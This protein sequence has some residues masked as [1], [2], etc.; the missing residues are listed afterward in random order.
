[1]HLGTK[2][3]LLMLL[4]TIGSSAAVSWIVTLNV[5]SY[6][7]SRANDQIS[8]AITRYV[9]RV[10]DRQRQVSK[11]VRALLESPA[12]RSQLQA[13]DESSDEGAREQLRQ[14]IFGREVQTELTSPEGTPAFHVLVNLA[15]DVV[16]AVAPTD[17]SLERALQTAQL[18]WPVDVVANA[19]DRAGSQY[20]STP[21][22]L[23][24]AMAV[25]LRTS[26]KTG[27][28]PSHIYFVGFRVDDDWVHRQLLSDRAAGAIGAPLDAWFTVD[29]HIVA[30]GSSD[31]ADPRPAAFRPDA[32][33][34]PGPTAAAAPIPGGG[35]F[36][37]VE[38]TAGRETFLGQS[39][40]LQP[41]G[42]Q[43]G[44]LILASSLDQAL[45]SLRRLQRQI[46]LTAALACVVAVAACR[47]LARTISRPVEQLVS[48]TER[49]AAGQFDA[50]LDFHRH[51][52]FGTLADSF[53]QMSQ[54]LKERDKLRDER[55]KIERDLALARKIQMDVLP[56]NLPPCA[57]YSIAACS[58]PAEATGGDIY[59]VVAVALDPSDLPR[60]ESAAPSLVLLLADATGHGVGPAL[61]VTQV[62]AMLRIGVRL[63]AT[64]D[65]IFSQINRQLCQDLGSDRFV[66]AFLGLLNPSSHRVNYHSAGQG[67]LLHFHAADQRFEWLGCSM[68]PLGVDEDA[69]DDDG[70]QHLQLEP[71]DLLVLLTDG[72]FEYADPGD[73]K[74]GKDRVAEVIR[75]H[76]Q[77]SARDLLGALL[78]TTREF[79]R[80]AAQLDD[81]TALIIKRQ[82]APDAATSSQNAVE[83]VTSIPHG[84]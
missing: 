26:F 34:R 13:A 6:E 81:M 59:D 47:G 38:F 44:R 29:G 80:G 40:S 11:V 60:T 23:F 24:L 21:A 43:R 18:R 73:V 46:L 52:E 78:A 16:I 79:A 65:D 12:S 2:I 41:V 19:P 70:V 39:F 77:E 58:Y 56:K 75:Q 69:S 84:L 14:E 50:P 66:T 45:A 7:T 5:T 51:D 1:M 28:P 61:S 36:E 82:L 62:R 27:E 15:G 9:T 22:G 67:P 55:L 83:A 57:G 4:I 33:L 64:L 68:M 25:P 53:N 49:I 71:G 8:Q 74:F 48:G 10:E 72:F 17:P 42:A 63:R 37:S 32:A 54:G 20:V 3:L 31:A 30:R 35:H 76:Y